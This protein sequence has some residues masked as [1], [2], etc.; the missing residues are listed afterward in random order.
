[1]NSKFLAIFREYTGPAQ[2]MD[3]ISEN[4]IFET[5]AHIVMCDA[6][7]LYHYY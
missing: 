1:M 5:T 2:M 6:L 7:I 3:P 4:S